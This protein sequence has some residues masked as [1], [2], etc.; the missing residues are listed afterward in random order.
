MELGSEIMQY[1]YDN[2]NN[3]LYIFPQNLP[4]FLILSAIELC[5]DLKFHYIHIL[6]IHIL[7]Y[8]RRDLL[9]NNYQQGLQV[10]RV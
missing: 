9:R 1:I 5:I 10:V 7:K 2:F 3:Y 8:E 6:L 4:I